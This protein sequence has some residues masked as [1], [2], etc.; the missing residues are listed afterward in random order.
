MQNYHVKMRLRVDGKV[1]QSGD[2]VELSDNQATPL[3]KMNAVML[4]PAVIASPIVPAT[5][6]TETVAPVAPITPTPVISPVISP[7]TTPTA[8]P[9]ST[10]EAISSES[11]PNATLAEP[12]KTAAA[13]QPSTITGYSN[14]T[15]AQLNAE[16][17]K[18]GITRD[19]KATNEVLEGLLL[20]DDVAKA[21]ATTTV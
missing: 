7:V 8:E 21:T 12:V 9:V 17:D 5:A 10:P 19:S 4:A 2:K 1:Y 16:L 20:A 6:V 11:T 14:F 18:R 13:P 3:L 15:K